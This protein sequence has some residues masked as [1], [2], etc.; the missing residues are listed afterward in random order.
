[1]RLGTQQATIVPDALL[2]RIYGSDKISE[3]HRH[4]YEVNPNWVNRLAQG[5]L[6]ISAHSND[7]GLVECIERDDHPWFVGCQFHPE[8]TSNPRDS[9]PLFLSFIQAAIAHQKG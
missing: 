1:M 2:Q 3:R 5:G 7:A 8:F 4:R 9:H 6:V